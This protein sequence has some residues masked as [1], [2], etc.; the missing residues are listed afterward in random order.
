MIEKLFAAELEHQVSAIVRAQTN[1][2]PFQHEIPK[3]KKVLDVITSGD[4]T[5]TIGKAETTL[6]FMRDPHYINVDGNRIRS[7]H[8][9]SIALGAAMVVIVKHISGSV[10]ARRLSR[11]K[12]S[13]AYSDLRTNGLGSGL[14]R[15]EFMSS[16]PQP[17]VAERIVKAM[18]D[19]LPLHRKAPALDI[20][21]IQNIIKQIVSNPALA[22]AFNGT[23]PVSSK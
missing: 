7:K 10:S 23:T 16:L 14:T 9:D 22:H 18:E 5:Y 6:E 17:A 11:R 3:I 2:S 13:Y 8:H 20:D 12:G 4:Y 1:P 19:N 15:K 21:V